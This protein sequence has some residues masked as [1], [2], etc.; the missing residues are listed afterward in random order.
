MIRR[1]S[2][3][4][5]LAACNPVT[6][7]L[8]DSPVAKD[9]PVDA[10]PQL[11]TV[12]VL[13]QAG[14]GLPVP[15][16]PV[17]FINPDGTAV[18]HP[19]TDLQGK[20]SAEVK[21]GASITIV[22]Q[23]SPQQFEMLTMLAV[24]PGDN[25]LVG[26]NN[27]DNTAAGNFAVTFSATTNATGYTI[28][29]PCGSSF[30]PSAGTVNLSMYKYC[31]QDMMEIQVLATNSAGASL[32]Y[33]SMSNVPLASGA[34]TMPSTYS[35]FTTVAATYNNINGANYVQ[36]NR[37][38]PRD[39]RYYT[40]SA[41][42]APTGTSLP[43]S[44][45]GPHSTT[46]AMR[47][48]FNNTAGDRNYVVEDIDPAATTYTLDAT[49]TLL[50]WFGNVVFDP[51]TATISMPTSSVGTTTDAPDFVVAMTGFSRLVDSTSQT[52]NYYR[53]SVLGPTAADI[54][55]PVLPAELAPLNPKSGD[56]AQLV[57]AFMVESSAIDGYDAVRPDPGTVINGTQTLR[58]STAKVRISMT[59]DH[60]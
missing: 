58:G 15:G 54:H 17:A 5:A 24:K 48:L 19:V 41:G 38:S 6:A 25:I 55:L 45:A 16:A 2:L 1:L 51:A 3:L 36:A 34:V 50:P 32:G 56:S 18:A 23:T 49:G 46:A 13:D 53:W 10:A 14:S 40:N 9:A 12:T 47:T 43:L 59:P 4:G 29:G 27:N 44:V 57:D 26:G 30:S 21:A 31:K 37:Y 28:L 7:H 52:Y 60:S 35:A 20:A 22:L 11:V 33:V 39:E 42:A 8:P